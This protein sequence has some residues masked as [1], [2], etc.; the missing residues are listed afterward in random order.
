MHAFSS[1]EKDE[2]NFRGVDDNITVKI[3]QDGAD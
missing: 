3:S 1:G 2:K